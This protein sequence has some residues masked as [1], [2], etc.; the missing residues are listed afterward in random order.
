MS[1]E[2]KIIKRIENAE[3]P[4]EYKVVLSN[5]LTIAVNKVSGNYILADLKVIVGARNETEEQ[6]GISHF[7]E[8]MIGNG[9]NEMSLSDV[10]AKFSE[11]GFQTRF[12]TGLIE[13]RF[14][15]DGLRRNFAEA[16]TTLLKILDAPSFSDELIKKEG[17]IIESERR[18]RGAAEQ[19]NMER[20]MDI[21][22]GTSY[23][24]SVAGTKSNI[25]SFTRSQLLE[26]FNKYYQPSN[27]EIAI[28]G[29]IDI[30][31]ILGILK[32]SGTRYFRGL[33]LE[34]QAE[35]SREREYLDSQKIDMT[36]RLVLFE[37]D[38]NA[39][40]DVATV[41]ICF[42]GIGEKDESFEACC[43][44]GKFL[45]HGLE[46]RLFKKV[47]EEKRL[48]YSISSANIRCATGDYIFT[49]ITTV[50][51]ENL[52]EVILSIAETLKDSLVN[53]ITDEE[54]QSLKIQEERIDVVVATSSLFELHKF[55]I[56]RSLSEQDEIRGVD[57]VSRKFQ[58]VTKEEIE[59]VFKRIIASKPVICLYGDKA[60]LVEATKGK[61]FTEYFSKEYL[62]GTS[63]SEESQEIARVLP[64]SYV[65]Q[66]ICKEK[67][68]NSKINPNL[69]LE[70]L[71]KIK[72][73]KQK[74]Q[75]VGSFQELIAGEKV[76]AHLLE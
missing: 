21:Y 25:F 54:L 15:I 55:F 43:L 11:L 17:G 19:E 64:V 57:S 33:S 9:T 20:K 74:K 36:S 51:F 48:C 5:G 37:Q 12:S 47:R 60:K 16:F 53:A 76:G 45:G 73:K 35:L 31:E 34:K 23:C 10:N 24:K 71:L 6:S 58:N 56:G 67:F 3:N 26:H 62:L 70:R 1:G 69:R 4:N 27:V 68:K 75:G 30:E 52:D 41:D 22:R 13:T 29:N 44:L 59:A 63:F 66:K 40:N 28:T 7:V 42:P 46:S 32:N 65:T 18:R 8:H 39:C 2:V 38:T 49:I 50:N 61:D 14:A 72:W